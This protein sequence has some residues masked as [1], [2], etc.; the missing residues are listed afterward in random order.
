[1]RRRGTTFLEL[2][3]ALTVLAVATA[4][5]VQLLVVT[6]A[7]R[8]AAWQREVAN[9]EAANLMEGLSARPWDKLTTEL[10]ADLRLSPEALPSLPGGRADIRIDGPSGTPEAKRIIVTIEWHTSNGVSVG[11]VRLVAWRYKEPGN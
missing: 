3:A 11:P 2:L 6:A 8:R 5:C 1:M 10:A 7:E 4:L 9:Q